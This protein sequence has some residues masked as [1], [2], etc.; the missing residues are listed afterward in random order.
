MSE[1]S[2]DR[3]PSTEPWPEGMPMIETTDAGLL[4]SR[5]MYLGLRDAEFSEDEA[6]KII[7]HCLMSGT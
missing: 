7:A 2:N 6:C 3:T 1:D 5:T 4:A